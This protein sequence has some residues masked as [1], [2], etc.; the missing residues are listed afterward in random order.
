MSTDLTTLLQQAGALQTGNDQV[1]D[2]ISKSADY[3]GRVQLFG[4]KAAAVLEGKIPMAH[5]G[6][7]ESKDAITDIGETFEALVLGYRPLASRLNTDPVTA[8]YDH[9]SD[10]FK[11]IMAESEIEDSG[12][13]YGPEFFLYVPSVEK[14]ATY[15]MNSKT[16]RKVAPQVK[17]LIGKAAKFKA[18][19]IKTAK[20]TWHGPEVLPSNSPL[21][22][23]A[24]E[25]VMEN[26]NKFLNPQ[27]PEA[28]KEQTTTETRDR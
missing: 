17:S 16:A 14:F 25:V 8:V 26:L 6:Y 20:Y 2:A 27:K 12:C 1:F 15:H 22:I 28:P 4:G 11:A 23:P 3:F 18:K 10:E 21:S 5:W 13:V 19:L 7:L 24:H 9:A